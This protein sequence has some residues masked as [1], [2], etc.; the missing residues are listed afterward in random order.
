M[1][2][3][4]LVVTRQRVYVIMSENSVARIPVFDGNLSKYLEWKAAVSAYWVSLV[5]NGSKNMRGQMWTTVTNSIAGPVIQWFMAESDKMQKLITDCCEKKDLSAWWETWDKMYATAELTSKMVSDMFNFSYDGSPESYSG[6]TATCLQVARLP[7]EEIIKRI[8]AYKIAPALRDRAIARLGVNEPLSAFLAYCI[9]L[10]YIP[11][12][13]KSIARP[14]S[15]TI[16][17]SAT[18]SAENPSIDVNAIKRGSTPKEVGKHFDNRDIKCWYCGKYGHLLRDC[19]KRKKEKKDYKHTHAITANVQGLQKLNG[20][21]TQFFTTVIVGG[22][23]IR[24]LVDT[25][26]NGS[27]VKPGVIPPHAVKQKDTLHAEHLAANSSTIKSIGTV[28]VDVTIGNK[29]WEVTLLVSPDLM[30]DMYLGMDFLWGKPIVIDF[31]AKTLSI[32]DSQG[33]SIHSIAIDPNVTDDISEEEM[34]RQLAGLLEEYKEIFVDDLGEYVG[35]ALVDPVEFKVDESVKPSYRRDRPMSDEERLVWE[36]SVRNQLECGAIE[37][38]EPHSVGWGWNSPNIFV[39]KKNSNKKRHCLDYTRINHAILKWPGTLP[40]I[41]LILRKAASNKVHSTLDLKDGYHQIPLKKECRRYLAFEGPDGRQYQPTVLPFGI[42]IAPVLFQ[43]IMQEVMSGLSCV[44]ILID[45]FHIG[46]PSRRQHIEDVRQVLERLRTYRLRVGRQKCKF[47]CEKIEL[48]GMLVSYGSIKPSPSKVEGLLKLRLPESVKETQRFL[49][50]L[51]YYRKFI[52]RFAHYESILRT[53]ASQGGFNTE[54]FKEAFQYLLSRLAKLP[55]LK[56]YYGKH[57]LVVYTDAS[58]L[59][60]GAALIQVIHSRKYKRALEYPVAFASRVLSKT[61][62]RYPTVERELTAIHFALRTFRQYLLGRRFTIRTDHKPLKDLLKK[63]L[64]LEKPRWN[65]R[66]LEMSEF[67]FEVEYVEGRNNIMADMLSRRIAA[68]SVTFESLELAQNWDHEVIELLQKRGDVTRVDGIVKRRLR[69]GRFVVVLPTVFRMRAVMEAHSGTQGGHFGVNKTLE[70]L[71]LKFW[72]PNMK[73]DVIHAIS[74]CVNCQLAMRDEMK[75]TATQ[76]IEKGG[77]WQDVALDFMGPYRVGDRTYSVLVLIDQFSKYVE[78]K[79]VTNQSAEVIKEF[80]M[81]VFMRMGLPNTILTD[82]ATS[83]KA[84]AIKEIYETF[85]IREKHAAPYNPTANGIVERVIG[86]LKERLRRLITNTN[87]PFPT[88]VKQATAAYN[89]TPHSSTG[90]TPYFMMFHREP[91]LP[92]EVALDLREE[93]SIGEAAAIGKAEALR[94]EMEA[95]TA[96]KQTEIKQD[97]QLIKNNLVDSSREIDIGHRVWYLD[98]KHKHGLLSRWTGPFTVVARIGPNTVVIEGPGGRFRRVANVKQIQKVR[99]VQP[100]PTLEFLDNQGVMDKGSPHVLIPI[101]V[102][103]FCNYNE[104][105][106]GRGQLEAGGRSSEVNEQIENG[107]VDDDIEITG[108]GISPYQKLEDFNKHPNQKIK[109]LAD[110]CQRYIQLG[111]RN[112]WNNLQEYLDKHFSKHS[113]KD[114]LLSL[115]KDASND[116]EIRIVRLLDTAFH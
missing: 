9:Q 26:A 114:T 27:F 5:M 46:S 24:C 62:Q 10:H 96:L 67:D 90:R 88:L 21:P 29:S 108:V 32:K 28:T 91:R 83:F 109:T 34:Q 86:T 4:D 45:D 57:P 106:A 47:G 25:G 97:R 54:V 49:G 76:H 48:F 101:E 20:P 92:L 103:E 105:D 72:W 75:P 11:E 64:A 61:E 113:K 94:A 98:K 18:P 1:L 12:F 43:Q 71:K 31:D 7:P 100:T 19:R 102:D 6:F 16:P 65:A 59:A 51:N 81:D 84:R 30:Y 53:M 41:E 58:E 74:S 110:L 3:E 14:A 66:M 85:G 15:T 68:V 93:N 36:E 38:V 17:I 87:A 13:Q 104:S 55:E 69:D 39:P 40:N 99:D 8:A 116:R 2:T 56:P 95:R 22:C 42:T 80:L 89:S 33:A 63:D 77:V 107:P 23:P 35:K 112:N 52:P 70:R 60:V 111:T 37:P 73:E 115:V 44:Q 82:N 79:V 50:M 78:T